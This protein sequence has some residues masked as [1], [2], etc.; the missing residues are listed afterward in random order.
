[1]ENNTT[2]RHIDIT[3]HND[4]MAAKLQMFGDLRHVKALRTLSL[5][6]DDKIGPDDY[7]TDQAWADLDAVV[8]KAS[9]TLRN[10]H[11]YAYT[12]EKRDIPPDLALMCRWLPSVARKISLHTRYEIYE[13]EE[14]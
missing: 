10:V 1:L 11:I 8:A 2:L 12:D 4:E 13:I 9:D 5:R 7:M 14:D 6:F 3:T